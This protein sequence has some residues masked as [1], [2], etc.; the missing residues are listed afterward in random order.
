MMILMKPSALLIGMSFLAGQPFHQTQQVFDL[1]DTKAVNAI[2]VRSEQGIEPFVGV[3]KGVS[4]TV[5]F[6][7]DAPEKATG[8]VVVQVAT[9][10]L[11][12]GPMSESMKAKWCL[13]EK[14]YPT[15][16]LN[17]VA[18]R[19][20]KRRKG[21]LDAT[22]DA[23]FTLRGVTKRIQIPVSAEFYPGKLG[24][25]NGGEEPGDLLKI[26]TEFAIKRLDY[27]V[28]KSLGTNMVGNELKISATIVGK[29]VKK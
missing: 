3:A 7:P 10:D 27:G 8:K 20:V 24:D 29:C 5:S 25:R 1:T 4:G 9:F 23:D 14:T 12:M 26:R 13:D 2:V 16:T 22:A 21:G 18:V 15:I 11:T 17:L 19:E 6:N 28:A